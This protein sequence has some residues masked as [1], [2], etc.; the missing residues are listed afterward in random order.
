MLP[1]SL[2]F[3]IDNYTRFLLLSNLP[4]ST[5]PWP[6]PASQADGSTQLPGAAADTRSPDGETGP[7]QA[8]CA[9]ATHH[10]SRFY[11]LA[12]PAQLSELVTLGEIVA[13]HSRP[14][15][16]TRVPAPQPGPVPVSGES[17][18]GA[19]GSARGAEEAVAEA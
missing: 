16:P 5:P 1:R 7:E 3:E 13:V 19:D 15:G 9:T 2:T 6:H 18:L 4:P 14:M 12:R 11:A 10:T 17:V 8:S